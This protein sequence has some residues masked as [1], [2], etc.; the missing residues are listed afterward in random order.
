MAK[1]DISSN[2]VVT[3]RKQWCYELVIKI[4]VALSEQRMLA[5]GYLISRYHSYSES[6]R[7][8]S[9][10]TQSL[11]TLATGGCKLA[12]S[13]IGVDKLLY[14]TLTNAYFT[15]M[16]EI[17]MEN[18]YMQI[19][20]NITIY[21]VPRLHMCTQRYIYNLF[22]NNTYFITLSRSSILNK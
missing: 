19:Y 12:K 10:C 11:Y 4:F 8:T 15:A 6:I 20:T 16:M 18:T 22:N 13:F 21:I 14:A 9:T 3:N 7:F 17:H 1:I 5:A 2:S